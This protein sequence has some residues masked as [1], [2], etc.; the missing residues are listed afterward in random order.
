MAFSNSGGTQAPE[1]DA[2]NPNFNEF[3]KIFRMFNELR[4]TVTKYIYGVTLTAADLDKV[5]AADTW[6]SGVLY[7]ATSIGVSAGQIVAIKPNMSD[8]SK[9]DCI[10]ASITQTGPIYGLALSS[11]AAGEAAKLQVAPKVLKL[12][13]GLNPGVVYGLS[14]TPGLL[15]SSGTGTPIGTAISATEL[16]FKGLL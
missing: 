6:G 1:V 13:T 16:Y 12:F 14:K 11:A 2:A 15:T 10:P 4:D 7:V 8:T 5:T 3:V 9:L